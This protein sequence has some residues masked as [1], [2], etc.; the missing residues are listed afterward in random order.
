ML[1]IWGRANSSN[2]MKVMWGVGELG[3]PH[4]R[5][6]VGGAFGGLDTPE[7]LAM[8]PNA[9]VPVIREED[10]FTLWESN[11]ILRYL[12]RKHPAAGL[13]PSDLRAFADMDRW[14]E[15]QTESLAG[16]CFQVFAQMHRVAPDKRD[17]AVLASGIKETADHFRMLEPVLAKSPYLAGESFTLAD[18]AVGVMAYRWFEMAIE[19][20]SMPAVEA[21][22][23]RIKARPAFK[24]HV[25][26]GLS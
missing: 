16:P 14:M 26:L 12:A 7:F 24:T 13:A 6:D 1:T 3:L 8:N 11:A 4:Q 2:V 15:W 21:W 20:P 22:Y 10:G 5:I 9:L 25:A 19:R 18:V 17:P 23:A